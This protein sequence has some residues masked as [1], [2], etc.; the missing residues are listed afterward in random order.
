MAID[1]FLE[2]VAGW[3]DD[4]ALVSQEQS[5]SY[6]E[7]CELVAGWR[8]R[9]EQAG[10][11]RGSVVAVEGT[12]S[13]NVCAAFLAAAAVGAVIAPLT[14]L[15]R[16]HRAGMLE[17][18]EASLL[19]EIDETDAF[20]LRPLPTAV[21]NP[22]TQRLL[23]RGNPGLIVFSSGSSGS[24]KA[25]L[26]DLAAILGKFRKVRQRKTTLTFLL[27]DHIGGVDTMLNTFG[28][29]GTLVT[30][31]QR[32]PEFVAKAIEQHRVHTLPVSPSFL[33]LFLMSGVWETRDLSSLKI[34]AYGTE[35]MPE[36]TLKRL[37]EVFPDV[38]LVQTYGMSE[39]GVLRSRSKSSD[40]LWLKFTGEEFRFR[41]V[42]GVLWIKADTAML[43]YLNAPDLFDA[44]GW[45]NTQDA[46]EVEGEYLRILGRA[47][48]L[49]NVG[50]QKV[51][52]AEVEDVLLKLENV[53]DATVFGKPHPMLGQIVAARVS[54]ARPEAFDVFKRRVHAFCRE[55]LARYQIPVAL[56]LVE[57]EQLGARFKKRRHE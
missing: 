13:P 52:P 1:W 11:T 19:V 22:L 21:K 18:A 4:V 53:R 57:A 51:Y 33:N 3:G 9:F 29:G 28:S 27:F 46:V 16:T 47:S 12:F 39:L 55:R 56:E 41:V 35:P 24:P 10:V 43:G 7:L 37:H 48:D 45:L 20:A 44:E 32:T 5:S 34:I 2:R 30:V 8:T 17:V 14:P 31:R 50:G 26:H 54:L 23:D 15:M 36:T 42:D 38:S 6:R 49:I 40:S 25:I